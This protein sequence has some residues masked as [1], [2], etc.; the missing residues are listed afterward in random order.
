[1][2]AGKLRHRVTLQSLATGSP[3][4]KPT[5]EP[6][7]AWA[8]LV[9]VWAD[10]RPL[11]GNALFLAQQIQSD[12]DMEIEIRYRAG[13]DATMRAVHGSDIYDIKAIVDPEKRH[14]R[15][16]LQCATGVNDG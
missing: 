6:D 9:T 5:G 1:M 10:V 16:L 14:I 8:D 4:Q 2:K 12:V 15:L 11:K 3:Q 13:L 7:T